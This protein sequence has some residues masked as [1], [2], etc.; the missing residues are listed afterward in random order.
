MPPG[1]RAWKPGC[2][3]QGPCMLNTPP[4]H[5][6]LKV[7]TYQESPQAERVIPIVYV[8]RPQR[9]EDILVPAA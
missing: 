3:S 7:L 4:V 5:Q 2:W 6:F 1:Y 8:T 9:F